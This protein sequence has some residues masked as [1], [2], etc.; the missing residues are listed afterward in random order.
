VALVTAGCLAALFCTAFAGGCVNA[1]AG[2]GSLLTFPM[3][4]W[5]GLPP[6]VAN[7]TNTVSIFPGSFAAMLPFRGDLDRSRSWLHTLLLPSLAGGA[8][9]AILLLAT[10]EKL[11]MR[12]VPAL[13]LFAT[14][15]FALQEF[16]ARMSGG[17]V[18]PESGAA[19]EPPP[20][21]PL[22]AIA[23]QFLISVYGGYFGAGIGIMMLASLG[24][25]G[26]RD[27]HRRMAVRTCLATCINGVAAIWFARG[28]AV[29]W[30]VAALMTAG[31]VAG[32]YGGA[33]LVRR[34]PRAWVR[35]S[36]VAIG[37]GM[38]AAMGFWGSH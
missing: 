34:V 37:L 9:G 8:L 20:R 3:L 10:P 1:L 15:I 19:D 30:R 25:L 17:R 38:A 33:S 28:G 13:I 4:V 6:I 7:G 26:L 18:E 12:L 23:S 21:S 2:G 24:L 16:F 14:S 32:G 29:D 35:W 22:R 36:V 27:L 11:F 31:Q 5:A